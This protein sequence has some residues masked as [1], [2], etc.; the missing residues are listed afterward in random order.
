M[1]GQK[2]RGA[3][4]MGHREGGEGQST[5]VLMGCLPSLLSHPS[6]ST[7]AMQHLLPD[8]CTCVAPSRDGWRP[9]P[10]RPWSPTQ[11][12]LPWWSTSLQGACLLQHLHYTQ[13]ACLTAHLRWSSITCTEEHSQHSR[14]HR[15]SHLHSH[16]RMPQLSA[17]TGSA[18]APLHSP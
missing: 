14:V 13:Q 9:C 5:R 16:S 6:W 18:S 3:A 11:A 2:S 10:W 4:G 15:L 7:E 1:D 12:C 8:R 17:L